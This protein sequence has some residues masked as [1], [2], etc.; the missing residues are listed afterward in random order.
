MPS[1]MSIK[2][3]N[4]LFQKLFTQTVS[5]REFSRM[6]LTK[7]LGL[8]KLATLGR[9]IKQN[10]GIRASLYQ[11][12]RTDDLKDGTLVGTDKYGNKYFNNPRYFYGRDRWVI[13]NEKVGVEYDGSMIPA[14]WFGWMHHKTDI[15]PTEKPPVHYDWMKEHAMNPSGTSHQYVP[16]STTKPKIQSWTPPSKN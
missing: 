16:Y 13:Y 15:P 1:R 4:I 5:L 14:E 12:Y 8:D 2:I 10:G 6:S 3:A 7:W 11:I 9:I